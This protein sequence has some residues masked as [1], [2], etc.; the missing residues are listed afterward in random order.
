MNNPEVSEIK[1]EESP[2][3]M[4]VENTRSHLKLVT[5]DIK[6]DEEICDELEGIWGPEQFQPF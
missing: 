6:A 5:V 2:E 1:G 3:E 4:Q